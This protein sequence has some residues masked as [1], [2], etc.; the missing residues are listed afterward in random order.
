MSVLMMRYLPTIDAA[1]GA[2]TRAMALGCRV[3][4]VV[5][6]GEAYWVW[7]EVPDGVTSDAVDAAIDAEEG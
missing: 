2:A 5:P 1:F 3:V 4:A 6:D 7:L